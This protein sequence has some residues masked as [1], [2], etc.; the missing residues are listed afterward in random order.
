MFLLLFVRLSSWRL[1]IVAVSH[2][3]LRFSLDDCRMI[4]ISVRVTESIFERKTINRASFRRHASGLSRFHFLRH[5]FSSFVLRFRND[6]FL[7]IFHFTR[8]RSEQQCCLRAATYSDLQN[9][10]TMSTS[11][12]DYVAH[13]MRSRLCAGCRHSLFMFSL[14]ALTASWCIKHLQWYFLSFSSI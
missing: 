10:N 6:L 5:K 1:P 12:Y 14:S 9:C 11:R 8:I 13:C 4:F 7:F 3:F 2:S